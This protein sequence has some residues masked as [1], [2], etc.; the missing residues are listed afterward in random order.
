MSVHTARGR[1][2]PAAGR[3]CGPLPRSSVP[4][5][6]RRDGA[7]SPRRPLG[8]LPRSAARALLLPF[9]LTAFSAPLAAQLTDDELRE[10][11]EQALATIRDLE[12]RVA[13]LEAGGEEDPLE[14][15]LL[16]LIGDEEDVPP[17]RTVFPSILNPRIAVY[18]DT[19]AEAGN[20]EEQLGEDGDR[21]SLRET[22]VDFRLPISPFAEGVLV[23]TFED[24]GN[25]EV[26]TLIEE[27]YANINVNGLTGID[28]P[29]Q[30]KVG[31]FRVPFGRDN[32]LHV[33][34]LIQVDRSFPVMNLVGEEG[35]IGDGVELTLP[36]THTEDEDGLGSTTTVW[37]A[38]VNGE[39]FTGEESLLGGLADDAGVGLDSDA[40]VIVARAS[41]YMELD[42][43]SDLEIGASYLDRLGSGA[44]MTDMGTKIRPRMY[45]LDVTWR[46]RPEENLVGSWLVTGEAVQT[47]FGYGRAT[48]P[49]FPSGT[50]TRRGYSVTAQRQMTNTTYAGLRYGK[51]DVLG[52]AIEASDISPYVSWYPTEFFRIRLQGQ[53]IE[54]DPGRNANRVFM[55][56]TWNFGSHNPHPYWTNL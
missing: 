14:A 3:A 37:L 47:E 10:A 22:E 19:V 18:M 36:L 49:G 48:A 29:A 11:L 52:T 1:R 33:H 51:T 12:Q 34:D 24:I 43:R 50:D 31:R 28:T 21:F 7:P 54:M 9:A 16:R 46:Q 27:G 41:Q 45:G 53:H 35:L 26:E 38:V 30:S 15:Q 42:P 56:A 6:V 2:A 23:T 17:Q 20:A 39:M 4:R 5:A 32:K 44:V 13:T 8:A 25:G 40:P 55:Q